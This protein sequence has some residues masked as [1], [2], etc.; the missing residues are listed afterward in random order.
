MIDS[1]MLRSAANLLNPNDLLHV[2]N[3]WTVG[4]WRRKVHLVGKPNKISP[5]RKNR[6]HAKNYS[7]RRNPGHDSTPLLNRLIFV[8]H[9]HNCHLIP[10]GVDHRLATKNR[11]TGSLVWGIR[12]CNKQL[13]YTTT[14]PEKNNL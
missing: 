11:W 7:N 10:C 13:Y 6:F 12:S 5:G 14:T 1:E 2:R 8:P 3:I 4:V 9:L